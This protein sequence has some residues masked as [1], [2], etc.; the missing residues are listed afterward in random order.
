M[1]QGCRGVTEARVATGQIYARELA[2]RILVLAPTGD[3]AAAVEQILRE[4]GHD[5]R[6]V[7]DLAELIEEIATSAGAAVVAAE[8]LEER[9]LC[10]RFREVLERQEPW[11]DIP[12]LMLGGSGDSEAVHVRELLGVSAH[13]VILER[14]VGVATFLTALDAALRSRRRQY[15]VKRLLAELAASAAEIARAHVEANHA[16]DE[17]IATL[18]HE[19]RSPITA[20]SGWIQLLRK[21]DLDPSEAADALSMIESSAKVQAHIIEDLMDVSRI[22]TG[23]VM[24]EPAVVDLVPIMA[25]VAVTFRPAAAL[26]GIDLT[27]DLSAES[28][29]AWAD[30]VRIQQIGW[31]LISNA[32]KFTPR[33]GS[34]KVSLRRDG[35][36]AVIRVRD[37]GRGI[38]PDL[39]P[40][41]FERYRQEEGAGKRA[42]HG[43]GLG[44]SIVC[45]LVES[46]GGTIRAYSEGKDRGADFVVRLPLHVSAGSG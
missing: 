20:I 36:T 10:A 38:S 26:K 3:D 27:T 2:E 17:F 11:S 41:I 5:A 14:P 35:D 21:G 8:A 7:T 44:L 43:L 46:H 42:Q 23:K 13:V 37:T 34:V 45:H 6:V 9:H 4:H 12:L 40:H 30:E 19:L 22:L 29:A 1:A 32:I 25:K 24:I 16:K 28:L 31:N 39:L 33:G 15:E 18:A